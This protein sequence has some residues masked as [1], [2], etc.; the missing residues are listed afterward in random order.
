M[1][2]LTE[3]FTLDNGVDI[4]KIGFG[5]WQIPNGD[6]AYNAVAAA[7][8]A[9]Y[10]HIDTARGYG[11]EESVGR[12]I[13]DSGIPRAEI[14]VTTKLPAEVKSYAEAGESF[15]TTLSELQMDYVDLYLI[16][17]PWPWS[18]MGEDYSEGNAEAWRAM[19]EI[20]ES[21]RARAIGV[22]NFE[23]SDLEK[24]RVASTI[25]PSVNQIKYYVGHTQDETVA[26]CQQHDILVEGYSPLATGAILDNPDVR[27]I[28]EKYDKSV[29]QLCIR[30]VLQ[31]DVLPL[32]K[33]TTPSRMTENADVE[34][35]ISAEDMAFLDGLTDT[36]S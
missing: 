19:E 36:A 10:R 27:G 5:T 3:Q 2:I 9:G 29:A 12:A 28:A 23:V 1:T 24:L 21:G 33:T 30:Y 22:S 15:A 14:F 13:A 20:Y 35:E 11:N 4:P 26:Y 32:P 16:H 34:F 7:L 6:D 17:A 8:A 18:D 31:K 25:K